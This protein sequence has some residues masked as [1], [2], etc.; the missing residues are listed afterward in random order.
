[1]RLHY[2]QHVPFENLANIEI[3]AKENNFEITSTKIFNEDTFPENTDFDLLVIMGGPMS[4]YEENRYP[5]LKNEK[6]FVKK[7]ISSGKKILGICLGAQL[8]ADTL[9]A[10]VYKGNKEIGWYEIYKTA[11]HPVING[12]NKIL[13]GFHWHGDTFDIPDG[14][15]RLFESEKTPNQGFIY[16][17]K[18]LALQFHLEVT[19]ERVE[20]LIENSGNDMQGDGLIQDRETII[21]LT[22]K[23]ESEAKKILFTLL[24]N[25]WEE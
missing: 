17:N 14:G 7:T 8:I 11:T 5:W 16:N 9:G 24:D 6:E 12:I 23:Y 15:I 19:P 20:E 2:I 25:F 22:K 10:D 13:Q 18:V 21:K 4:V 1:M 3:W